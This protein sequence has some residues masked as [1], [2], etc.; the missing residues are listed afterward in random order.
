MDNQKSP[1]RPRRFAPLH[2]H[3]AATELGL[4][5]L[6]GIIFDVDGTLVDSAPDICTAQTEVLAAAG[7]NGVSMEQLRSY[8]GLEL[9]PGMHT[10]V[11]Q[12]EPQSFRFILLLAGLIVLFLAGLIEWRGD[13]VPWLRRLG[14]LVTHSTV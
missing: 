1:H 6:K 7:C 10:V 14:T 12:Y 9:V 11:V 4:P 2:S 5:T 13:R 8:V 3:E